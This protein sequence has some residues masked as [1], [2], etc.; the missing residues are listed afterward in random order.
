V[1]L[2]DAA[3][4]VHR[5]QADHPD[6]G[7]LVALHKIEERGHYETAHRAKQRAGQ[8]FRYAI[9]TQR[10]EHDITA[11]MEGAL[12]AVDVEHFAAITYPAK[13]G[14]LMLA[15]DSYGRGELSSTLAA[16]RLAPLVFLRPGELCGTRWGGF[17]DRA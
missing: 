9:A 14:E 17:P 12:T 6:H 13:V 11:D 15:V 7:V 3:V 1:D 2:R 8:V 4:S 16:L 10:A 5:R